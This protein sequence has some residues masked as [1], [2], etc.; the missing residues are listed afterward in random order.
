MKIRGNAGTGC[1]AL[2]ALLSASQSAPAQQA[3][4]IP[5]L[6]PEVTVSATRVERDSFDIPASIDAVEQREIRE[7]RP[8]VNLSEALNRVPGIVVQNRQNYAQDLQISSRGF[9]ARSTFGVRGLR[10]YADG[11]P[12]TMPDGQGQAASF[13]LSSAQ[14]IEVLRGPFSSLYGNSAGGVVQIFTQDGPPEPTVTVSGVAG[15]YETTKFGLQLGGQ[16]G[17]VNYTIDASRFDTEGYRDH[18]AARRDHVNAKF[19]LDA[20][21]R[22]T[23]T[24]VVNALDQPETQDPLGL[25]AAQ[26]AQNRRQPGSNALAFNTRKSISQ[27]QAGLVYD[28]SLTAQDGIQLRG[29][30][31]DRQVTQFLA[32]PLATQAALTHAGGVVDLDR[33]YGGTGLR[34]IRN[35]SAAGM[36]LT[37]QAGVDYE[38][39]AERR[40]GFRNN[41]GVSG[42]LQRDENDVVSSTDFYA[43]AEWAPAPKWLVLAGVRRS[44]VSFDSRDFFIATGNGDDSGSIRYARTTPAAGVTYKITPA[45]NVYANAGKGFETPTFA[46]LAYRPSGAT[47]LN[48]SLQPSD[49]VHRE[50]GLKALLGSAGRVNAALF[51]IDTKNEIVVDTSAGGRATFKNA[52]RTER[53]GFELGWQNRYPHG[54]ETAVAYTLLRATFTESFT[55]LTGTPAVPVK[56]NA[57]SRMP[58]VPAQTLYGELA[59]RYPPTGFHAGAELRH[60]GKIYV[61]DQ[62]SEF[63]GAYTVANLRAGFEQRGKAWTLTQFV[64][65]DNVTDRSYIGSVIVAEGNGRYYEPAPG[66]T[67]LVGVSGQMR[68]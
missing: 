14:R 38:R 65:I 53:E 29:Y 23:L 4:P 16:R 6:L 35:T 19:K 24:F 18:S 62:N 61:N 48:L 11:I 32:I 44:R 51:R 59:W 34:W 58:G 7:G 27:G 3:S 68:F 20:G 33:N 43:Q 60:S 52:S 30:T 40:K 50:I 37:L 22:G 57:G 17:M 13:N 67:A 28:V 56:V 31:G 39:M 41:N 63:A 5:A 49:S 12:A 8:Q 45:L 15:S 42:Q 21:T 47:G 25:T 1:A 26:V 10:L 64:R 9:G 46:E 55:T 66:R 36:P 2:A 54:F